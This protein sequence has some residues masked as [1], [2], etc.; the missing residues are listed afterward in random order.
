MRVELWRNWRLVAIFLLCSILLALLNKL[1]RSADSSRPRPPAPPPPQLGCRYAVEPPTSAQAWQL[2]FFL[3]RPSEACTDST[4]QLSAGASNFRLQAFG[5]REMVTGRVEHIG[6]DTYR[7]RLRLTFEDEYIIMVILTYVNNASLE[8]RAHS[9]PVL[10]H[11]TGSP[12]EVKVSPGPSLPNYT[13]YC[14]QA[15]SGTAAGRWVECG[16]L[17]GVEKCGQWQLDP[18]YDFDRIHGFHWLPYSCQLHHYSNDEIKKCFAQN[19][20]SSLVF[21]GDSHMRYRT[22]HW[23]TRLHGGCRGCIKTHVKMVFRKIPRVEWMFDAR[24][25]RWPLTFPNISLP[26]EI[27][28]HPRT[29]RS[30]FSKELPLSVFAGNLFLLNFGHWVLRES[31]RVSYMKAKLAAFIQALQAINATAGNRRFLWV[32]TVSLPWREDK[33]VVDWIENP[34]PSRVEQWNALSDRAMRQSGIQVVDAFQISNGRIGATHDQTHF[35]KRLERGDCGGVV[36]NAISNVIAN[37]LCNYD[38]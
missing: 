2:V 15:E 38:I 36:E 34:S 4:T 33:A 6:N 8:F 21:T 37:A 3:I 28:V 17:P 30:M 19:S 14:G 20:W 16:S 26:N 9:P 25:T 22:Y 24:G 35:A 12:L 10:Q 32:N 27:Y 31:T 7:G 5:N 18:V 1:W 13:R 11:V 23:V 29:R